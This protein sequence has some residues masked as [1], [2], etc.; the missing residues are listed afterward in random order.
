[1]EF[2]SLSAQTSADNYNLA[3]GSNT[4]G[5]FIQYVIALLLFPLIAWFI[6]RRKLKGKETAKEETV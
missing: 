1:M 2:S 4:S 3:M 5:R 6:L